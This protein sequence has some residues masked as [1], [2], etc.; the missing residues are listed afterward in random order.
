MLTRYASNPAEP[1]PR[2]DQRSAGRWLA[3]AL[4]GLLAMA[5]SAGRV[6]AE[7]IALQR[8]ISVHGWFTWPSGAQ[9]EGARDFNWPPFGRDRLALSPDELRRLQAAGFD[10]IRLTLDPAPFIFFSGEQRQVLFADLAASLH[11]M[12]AA[13]LKIVVDFHPKTKEQHP[14]W[15]NRALI[16]ENGPLFARLKDLTEETARF[17]DSAGFT[18]DVALELLNEPDQPCDRTGTGPRLWQAAAEQLHARARRGSSRLSLIVSGACLGTIDGLLAL[19]PRPMRDARTLFTFHH[20]MPFIFTHQGFDTAVARYFA[21][22]PYP[23]NAGDEA[24]TWRAV[25]ARLGPEAPAQ[26]R[27]FARRLVREHFAKPAGLEAMRAELGRVL[28]WAQ[29]HDVPARHVLMGEFG[30]MRRDMRGNGANAPDRMRWIRDARS[31]A[32][33]SGFS[34]AFW[35]YHGAGHQGMDFVLEPRT[36]KHDPDMTCALGLAGVSC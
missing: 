19:D 7:P 18:P 5:S 3:L 12:R 6:L 35:N 16:E 10:F 30:V 13:G 9:R 4:V 1:N 24:A 25:E 20:Y 28:G 29:R 23:A 33:E 14:K 15:G 17:L 36:R 27:A 31:L 21:E 2:S 22:V 8:G 34:W 11:L 32:E 26:A